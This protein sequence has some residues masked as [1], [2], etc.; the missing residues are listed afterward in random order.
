ML[1]YYLR[2]A[3]QRL[4]A[5]K[6][7]SII[8]AI[9]LTMGISCA[10][11][12][13]IWVKH[14]K[15]FDQ[16]HPQK[17][18]VYTFG[19]VNDESNEVSPFWPYKVFHEFPIKGTEAITLIK[20]KAG[21]NIRYNQKSYSTNI[22]LVDSLFTK[23]L[24][25]P[26]IHGNEDEF[27]NHKRSIILSE[28]TS[29]EIFG[30]ISPIGKKVI[31]NNEFYTIKGVVSVPSNSTLQ[32]E[33]LIYNDPADWDQEIF[34]YNFR[35]FTLINPGVGSEELRHNIRQSL[36]KFYSPSGE[37][38]DDIH[39]L[40]IDFQLL[41][42]IHFNPVYSSVFGKSGNKNYVII[43]TIV[44]IFI[45]IISVINYINLNV[46]QAQTRAKEV[47]VR[48]S[49]G[50]STRQVMIQF[51]IESIFI[52]LISLFF[53]LVIVELSF[54]VLVALLN[55]DI[56]L[57]EELTVG[58]LMSIFACTILLGAIA[59]LYPSIY[60]SE[61]PPYRILKGN[62]LEVS[63]KVSF[64]NV[65]MCIQFVVS[66][67]MIIGMGI[68][69]QQMKYINGYSLGYDQDKLHYILFESLKGQKQIK[70]LKAELKK[71]PVFE[72]VSTITSSITRQDFEQDRI[73]Y[74]ALDS[75][76]NVEFKGTFASPDFLETAGIEIIEGR[77]YDP[78][79]D[80]GQY[81]FVANKHFV[82]KYMSEGK[83]NECKFGNWRFEKDSNGI[84]IIGVIKDFNFLSL[85]HDISP[86]GFYLH[87]NDENHDVL[88][89]RIDPN[90]VEQAR[91]VSSGIMNRLDQGES[92]KLVS[93]RS[94]INGHYE[95]DQLF[96]DLFIILGCIATFI[97][98]LG[99]LTL[100][101]LMISS[102][103]KE[104]ALRKIFGESAFVLSLR[105]IKNFIL[106][107]FVAFIIAS[108]VMCLA[109]N[110]WLGQFSVRVDMSPMPFLLALI[111]SVLVAVGTTAY[112]I[113]KT[114]NLSPSNVLK[115]E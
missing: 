70:A 56:A 72:S 69:Y 98:S 58:T 28:K 24:N 97:A 54:D 45:L 100:S 93:N 39:E 74:N 96:S 94:L 17:E 47:A 65:M 50:A 34:N 104:V 75:V 37:D 107:I 110:N 48:K 12:V 13:F 52:C 83:F 35:A 36:M 90:N 101:S 18:R 40:G 106:L 87:P 11:Y 63:G 22:W 109:M 49:S 31:H 59:G 112:H 115:G 102:K 61:I 85:H 38:A 108:S 1:F 91:T 60:L 68:A 29:E 6:K 16:F 32:F 103:A 105:L 113:F 80:K 64:I 10:L 81:V 43:F 73:M 67:S 111:I 86:W 30:N 53:S 23:C 89:V 82:K 2:L 9:G 21:K 5:L 26:V 114:V 15:S 27:F 55:Q 88:A 51:L 19:Y 14:E 99:L 84:K 95:S 46:T 44:G 3:I 78:K 71:H 79:L 4:L 92:I 33:A 7:N 77:N 8:S 66:I 20:T 76:V 42:E 25:F 41:D 62:T 57:Y